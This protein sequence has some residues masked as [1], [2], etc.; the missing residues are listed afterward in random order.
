M[1]SIAIRKY[2]CKCPCVHIVIRVS[3]LGSM[4]GTTES[5]IITVQREYHYMGNTIQRH[6]RHHTLHTASLIQNIKAQSTIVHK[7]TAIS[8][9]YTPPLPPFDNISS[10]AFKSMSEYVRVIT[11]E[12][13][14]HTH[15]RG[16]TEYAN[17]SKRKRT[18]IEN[19]ERSET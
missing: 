16:R 13:A 6:H 1:W 12:F 19:L 17:L 4:H 9:I 14:P 11:R 10:T 5:S 8:V 7:T 18:R 2:H 15:A 3:T